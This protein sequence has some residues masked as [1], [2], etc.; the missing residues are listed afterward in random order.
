M[1]REIREE[2]Y[3]YVDKTPFALKLAAKG[4]YYFSFVRA[5][6]VSLAIALLTRAIVWYRMNQLTREFHYHHN[7]RI[8]HCP[9]G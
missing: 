9:L 8:D 4:K 1:F 2:S 6:S 3:C 5:G 7:E